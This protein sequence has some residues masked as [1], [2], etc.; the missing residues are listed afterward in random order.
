MGGRKGERSFPWRR[1]EDFLRVRKDEQKE[2]GGKKE[3]KKS[4]GR[5]LEGSMER[6]HS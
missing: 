1:G 3:K 5:I 6:K 4:E 2:R